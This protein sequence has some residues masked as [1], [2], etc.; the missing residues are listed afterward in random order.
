M[1]LFKK[2]SAA[3]PG[4][5]V[6]GSNELGVEVG[7]SSKGTGGRTFIRIFDLDAAKKAA[8]STEAG[9]LTIMFDGDSELLTFLDALKFSVRVLQNQAAGD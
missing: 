5:L 4:R 6:Y 2:R 3:G 9:S 7:A 1:F 8:G